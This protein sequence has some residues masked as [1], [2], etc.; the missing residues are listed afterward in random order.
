MTDAWYDATS[1]DS[2]TVR[3]AT[4]AKFL[5]L[6]YMETTDDAKSNALL[7]ALQMAVD[8]L[9]GDQDPDDGSFPLGK[10]RTNTPSNP[11][12]HWSIYTGTGI[13]ARHVEALAVLAQALCDVH[14]GW[15]YEAEVPIRTISKSTGPN[16]RNCFRITTAIRTTSS[17]PRSNCTC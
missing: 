13:V 3:S 6:A 8:H 2:K 12:Y 5:A 4:V 14:P 9:S 1:R 16:T 17:T 15:S 7:P 11:G 10:V